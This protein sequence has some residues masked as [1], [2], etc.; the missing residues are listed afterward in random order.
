M[1][2]VT[3]VANLFYYHLDSNCANEEVFNII[4]GVA[5][6]IELV[7]HRCACAK[8]LTTPTN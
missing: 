7:G 3:E 8:A 6:A 2:D 4:S 1:F 5:R